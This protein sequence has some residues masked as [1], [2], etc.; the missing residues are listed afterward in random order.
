[1]QDLDEY[2]RYKLIPSVM[3]HFGEECLKKKLLTPEDVATVAMLAIQVTKVKTAEAEQRLSKY[4]DAVELL[5]PEKIV[6][7]S[8]LNEYY[9]ARKHGTEQQEAE[10]ARI[11]DLLMELAKKKQ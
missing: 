11:D 9:E 7:S 6:N 5:A 2:L 1:M 3:K 10:Q 4:L 8:D